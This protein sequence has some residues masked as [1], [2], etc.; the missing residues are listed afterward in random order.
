MS[1]FRERYDR[2]VRPVNKFRTAPRS[3]WVEPGS[4]A[5]ANQAITVPRKDAEE[6]ANQ[7]MAAIYS[8]F[9]W[10]YEGMAL[11]S[12]LG[13]LAKGADDAVTCPKCHDTYRVSW[14]V[15]CPYCKARH[16]AQEQIDYELHEKINGEGGQ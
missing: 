10:L 14:G 2:A 1:L 11:K 13:G 9:S 15:G 16:T 5:R 8:G 12:F 4:R 7:M 6:A 3:G